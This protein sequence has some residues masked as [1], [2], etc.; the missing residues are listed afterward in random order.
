MFFGLTNSLAIFQTMMN[1]L[2][3]GLINTEKIV[4]FT[5]DVIIGIEIEEG[6]DEIVVKV[7]K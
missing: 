5:D 4:S 1:K 3:Q 2:L 6:H 7:V